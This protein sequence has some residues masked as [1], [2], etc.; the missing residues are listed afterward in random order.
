M[1]ATYLYGHY[2]QL[3]LTCLH[4]LVQWV[5]AL[6]L[7][8]ASGVVQRR[9][10]SIRFWWLDA[11]CQSGS[12]VLPDKAEFGPKL[13]THWRTEHWGHGSNNNNKKKQR[14]DNDTEPAVMGKLIVILHAMWCGRIRNDFP[15]QWHDGFGYIRTC[16][17]LLCTSELTGI[18]GG[19]EATGWHGPQS[20]TELEV[21][22]GK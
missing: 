10:Q 4:F 19:G 9:C 20:T 5:G 6:P 7:T 14:Q 8:A 1:T 15:T 11:C 18:I 12:D 21:Q 13:E 16:I 22:F 2:I 17:Y 3:R